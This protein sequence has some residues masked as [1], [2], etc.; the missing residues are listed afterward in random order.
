MVEIV[1]PHFEAF[2]L[3]VGQQHIELAIKIFM[4]QR[5]FNVGHYI[6]ENEIAQLVRCGAVD[7][8]FVDADKVIAGC[9]LVAVAQS[10]EARSREEAVCLRIIEADLI[11]VFAV[12]LDSENVR[13]R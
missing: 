10:I 6:L 3:L 7:D 4:Y 13:V 8:A 11:I 9:G 12:L 1:S 5:I 2:K